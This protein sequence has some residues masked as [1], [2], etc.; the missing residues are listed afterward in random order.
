MKKLAQL[1]LTIVFMT[2]HGAIIATT[3]P[4][5]MDQAT[6]DVNFEK[7]AETGDISAL[8]QLLTP[9]AEQPTPDPYVIS[10]AFIKAVQKG[11]LAVVTVLLASRIA[12][13]P[14][15]ITINDTSRF[16]SALSRET[17][18]EA[19]NAAYA[20]AHFEIGAQQSEVGG[21]SGLERH[22][23]GELDRRRTAQRERMVAAHL[24]G[25]GRAHE[26][27]VRVADGFAV[28]VG[29]GV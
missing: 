7:A 24:V 26:A 12:L 25:E 22:R 9:L 1:I 3:P 11:D 23:A 19:L 21:R 6:V 10:S 15:W 16:V 5:P 8:E 13:E 4:S 27:A 2:G 18:D 14:K 20:Q 28:A 17:F 29:F